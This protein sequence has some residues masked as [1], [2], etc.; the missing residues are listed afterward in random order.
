MSFSVLAEKELDDENKKLYFTRKKLIGNLDV[1]SGFLTNF[2]DSKAAF[3]D[4]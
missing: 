4:N 1:A 3:A 2:L